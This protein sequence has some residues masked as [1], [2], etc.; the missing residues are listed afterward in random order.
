MELNG[1]VE[2]HQHCRGLRTGCRA[3]GSE[4]CGI[5]AVDNARCVCPSQWKSCVRTDYI[6]IGKTAQICLCGYVIALLS[7][8]A[9]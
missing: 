7:R 5:D 8:I 4:C 9:I 3:V 6:C 1:L 2:T